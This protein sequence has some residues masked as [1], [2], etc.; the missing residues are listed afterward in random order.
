M[1]N[2]NPGMMI[3]S[4]YSPANASDE[5]NLDTFYN[6]LSSL[7]RSIPN[8]LMIRGDVNAQIGKDKNNK[9]S[10]EEWI[11]K[12]LLGNSPKVTGKPLIKIID[13]QLGIKLG[14][15]TQEELYVVLRK[16]KNRKAASLNEILPEGWKT[17]KFNDLILRCYIAIYNQNTIDGSTKYW[18]L[19]IPKK[20]DLR[21]AKN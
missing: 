8:V 18:T 1:F 12:K 2:N 13:N 9:F 7:V 14:Q 16:I 5:K 19:T 21:I 17:R 10:Q 15:F 3:I 6:K 20:D 11:H 4:C